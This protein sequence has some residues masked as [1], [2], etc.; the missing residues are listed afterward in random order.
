[1]IKTAIVMII[2]VLSYIMSCIFIVKR[3]EMF[4]Q[5]L[6]K[7]SFII[8][9]I[10]IIMVSNITLQSTIMLVVQLPI[11]GALQALSYLSNKSHI[12]RVQRFSNYGSG[13]DLNLA[14]SLGR[15]P[16]RDP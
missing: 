9:I 13:P 11:E 8:I 14:L 6:Y 5:A 7:Y 16:F 10:I 3:L 4:C 15:G 1:M 12:S 2:H